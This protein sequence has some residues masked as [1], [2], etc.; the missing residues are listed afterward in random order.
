MFPMS[1]QGSVIFVRIP[2]IDNVHNIEPHYEW[3]HQ[4]VAAQDERSPFYGRVY[5][6]FTFSNRVYNYLIHPQW[7]QF[8]STTLFAKIIYADYEHR[9]AII[10]L[11]GEWND[12]LYDDFMTMKH[13]LIDHLQNEGISK[14][15]L[16]CENVMNFHAGD[17]DYYHELHEEISE[18]RGW[19]VLVNLLE[20]VERE[21]HDNQLGHY[22]TLGYPFQDFAWRKYKPEQLITL[23][24]RHLL[25]P[26]LE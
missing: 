9:A 4:Y 24:D 12:C 25:A 20:H 2:R 5:S 22:V 23:V 3:R 16:I 7:D 6:E 8:G 21:F 26:Y 13:N 10:E 19:F 11:I 18:E 15:L 17:E 1:E 14:F